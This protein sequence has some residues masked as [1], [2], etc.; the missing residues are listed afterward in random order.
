M[1]KMLTFFTA[2]I[3]AF[4]YPPVYQDAAKS[5][6]SRGVLYLFYL[7]GL[8]VIFTMMVLSAKIMPQVDA[9][10]NWV[11]KNMPVLVWTPEGLSIENGQTTA[12][13]THPKYGTIAIFDM[14]KTT[15]TAAD[16]GKAYIFVT[17]QKIFFKSAPGQI[18]VRD[19]T[20]A[21]IKKRPFIG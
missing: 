19:V 13:L 7:A 11:Q 9:F 1:N 20:G 4:F 16:M 12:M 10:A 15:V 3:T 14:T 8:S 5:S 2:P 6:A 21:G 18:G 17:P